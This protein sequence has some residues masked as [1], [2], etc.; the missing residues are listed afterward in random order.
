MMRKIQ[1]V[2][3]VFVAVFA[4]GALMV[5]SASAALTFSL[6]QWLINK[7]LVLTALL[8]DVAE[9]FLL[10]N[11]S[12]GAD[13]DCSFLLEGTI[14][15]ESADTTTMI[16]NLETTQRLIEEL[17]GE[18]LLC[19]ALA[20]CEKLTP[21]DTEFWFVGLPWKTEVELDS[22]GGFWELT[23]GLQYHILCL[24]AGGLVTAEEL[25]ETKGGTTGTFENELL[26]V[27]GGV[28]AMG[29][30]TPNATCNTSEGVGLIEFFT[31]NLITSPEGTLEV[32]E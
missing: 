4:F 12:N 8:S 20:V 10:E 24:A 31:G 21:N 27:T 28:E 17:A 1:V 32:S 14:G 16:Y 18:G 2:G 25:C 29:Q 3:L 9:E 26:N 13:L 19:E 22:E 11:T 15:P 30:A 7:E 6:A 23:T 5:T